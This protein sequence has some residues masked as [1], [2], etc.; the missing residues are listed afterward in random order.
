MVVEERQEVELSGREISQ[1]EVD[2]VAL[3]TLCLSSQ[4]LFR[5]VVVIWFCC[6]RF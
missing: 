5:H 3:S 4:L 2:Q 6:C 1:E